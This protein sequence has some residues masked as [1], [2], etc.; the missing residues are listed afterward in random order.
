MA[1]SLSI[2]RQLA[3]LE[4]MLLHLVDHFGSPLNA[5]IRAADVQIRLAGGDLHA[6]RPTQQT[7]M[8]VGRAE[9]FQ[10]SVRV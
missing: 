5:G 2:H 10:L 1:C 9:Q 7:K 3:V 8:T 4:K 6:Q